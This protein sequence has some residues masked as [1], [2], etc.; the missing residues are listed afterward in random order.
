MRGY[1]DSIPKDHEMAIQKM[2]KWLNET[3]FGFREGFAREATFRW[4]VVVVLG[5]IIWRC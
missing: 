3:L 2:L 4:F 1:T 5:F